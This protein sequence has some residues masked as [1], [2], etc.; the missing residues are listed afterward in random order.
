MG[1]TFIQRN[2]AVMQYAKR[3]GLCILLTDEHSENC[4]LMEKAFLVVG[5]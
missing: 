4:V 1:H 2:A 5:F 3:G